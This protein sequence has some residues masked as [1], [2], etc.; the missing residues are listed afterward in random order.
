MGRCR[1]PLNN[2]S[3]LD[4]HRT[5]LSPPGLF[6]RPAPHI[7]GCTT[8]WSRQEVIPA[9]EN[10]QTTLWYSCPYEGFEQVCRPLAIVRNF[11]KNSAFI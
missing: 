6:P 3:W 2:S 4:S 10:S 11:G 9:L 7:L 5:L 1:L 8:S